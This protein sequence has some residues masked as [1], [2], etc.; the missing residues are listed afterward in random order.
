[1]LLWLL[2]RFIF[3]NNK[4]M[5][6]R[7]VVSEPVKCKQHLKTI[8]RHFKC[9]KQMLT[10]NLWL[11]FYSLWLFY[12][13]CLVSLAGSTSSYALCSAVY[14]KYSKKHPL[15][16]MYMTGVGRT[17]GLM[18]DERQFSCNS[19]SNILRYYFFYDVLSFVYCL[20]KDFCLSLSFVS[21]F[22]FLMDFFL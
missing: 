10:T 21:W 16:L 19:I 3:K 18:V 5:T 17:F 6:E 1:M 14:S 13:L 22:L 20:I 2:F 8:C 4:T 15:G 11:F 7:K 9:I 12:Y